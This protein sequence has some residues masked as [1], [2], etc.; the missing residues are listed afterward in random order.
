MINPASA[1]TGSASSFHGGLSIAAGTVAFATTAQTGDYNTG[2]IDQATL[3]NPSSGTI[4]NAASLKII[5][6]P[7]AGTNVTITNAYSLWVAGGNT[8]LQATTIA[9][10]LL[11]QGQTTHST[12][13]NTGIIIN[14]PTAPTGS[15]SEFVGAIN[16][17]AGTIGFITTAQSGDYISSKYGQTTLTNPSGGTITNAATL[18]IVGAPVASTNVTITNAY[19]LWIAGGTTLLQA[20]TING[21]LTFS[22]SSSKIL[23][24]NGN[25][26][27]QFLQVGSAVNYIGFQNSA[28][29]NQLQIQFVGTDSNGGITLVPKGTGICMGSCETIELDLTDE[30][31]L[32]TT[33]VKITTGIPYNF[34]CVAATAYLTTAGS[35]VTLVEMDALIESGVDTNTFATIFTTRPKIAAAKFTSNSSGSTAAVLTSTPLALTKDTRIQGKI[36]AID[37]GTVARGYKILLIGYR[38]S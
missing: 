31:T 14:P 10:T 9:T 26:I 21:N 1:P 25:G 16:K 35:G 23:D 11:V 27:V 3:T 24:T 6:A 7:I 19:A 12:T 13:T 36:Q 22:T 29:G 32:P 20:T 8:L 5:G 4:P 34:S 28:T 33:G 2:R 38:T 17:A 15:A 37:T 18:K 30:S